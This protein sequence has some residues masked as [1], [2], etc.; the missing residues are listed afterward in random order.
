[1]S[2]DLTLP[3]PWWSRVNDVADH[4]PPYRR[5][6]FVMRLSEEMAHH[7]A[8]AGPGML[9][10]MTACELAVTDAVAALELHEVEPVV[11]ILGESGR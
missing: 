11:P 7:L 2:L 3:S 4:L 9:G 6:P 1:M 10:R 8:L 5:G